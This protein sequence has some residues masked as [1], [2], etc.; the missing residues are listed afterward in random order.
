MN[1]ISSAIKYMSDYMGVAPSSLKTNAKTLG[2]AIN[3]LHD[4][5]YKPLLIITAPT[6]STVTVIKDG[7][8][9]TAEES[10]GTWTFGI[11]SFGTWTCT[12]TLSGATSARPSAAR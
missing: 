9:L 10:S 12:A 7:T 3:E 11:P 2:G 1:I 6:G 4:S 5:A 8:T